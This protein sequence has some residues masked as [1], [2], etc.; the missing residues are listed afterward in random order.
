MIRDYKVLEHTADLKIRA[1]GKDLPELFSNMLKGMFEAC[2]PII[3]NQSSIVSREV[4]I[5][6]PNLE[7]LLVD[8]LSEALY[9]SDVNDEIYFQA[10]FEKLTENELIGKLKGHKIKGLK[11]EIKAVTWHDLKIERR[12]NHWEAVVL[13]D[14]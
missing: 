13:F 14:I 7:S 3:S 12:N 1:Y 2:E 6:S 4:K 5:Q 10:E 9:L 11:E 8:F